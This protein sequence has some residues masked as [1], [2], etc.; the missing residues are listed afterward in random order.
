MGK[1]VLEHMILPFYRYADFRG[2]SRRKEFWSFGLLNIGV[3]AILAG[4]VFSTGFSHR[5]LIQRAEFGGTLGIG[6]TA[7][8]AILGI[9]SL[10]ALVPSVAVN[11][12]RLHDRGMSGWW[13]L[14]FVVLGVIPFLGWI[15]S[16]GYLVVMSLP[17]TSGTNRFGDDPRDQAGLEVPA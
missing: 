12:R 1:I 8:F 14:G 7:F 10:A 15:T 9:Y 3:V 5:A 4:L 17:G 2:R 16:I 13:C 11:V 6:T